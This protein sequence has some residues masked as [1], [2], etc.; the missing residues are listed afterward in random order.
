MSSIRTNTAALS[1]LSTLRSA[2]LDLDRTQERISSGLKIRSAK[3]NAAYFAISSTVAAD[4]GMNKAFEEGLTL[5]RNAISVARLATQSVLDMTKQIGERLMLAQTQY[6]VNPDF[7]GSKIQAEIDAILQRI[8]GTIAQASFNGVSLVDGHGNQHWDSTDGLATGLNPDTTRRTSARDYDIR[9]DQDVP[10][11][12]PARDPDVLHVA[13]GMS[14]GA[15]G[16]A[17]TT[18]PVKKADLVS[19]AEELRSIDVTRDFPA[20]YSGIKG[21]RTYRLGD[22]RI[23][24]YIDL[25]ER[26]R[27]MLIDDAAALGQSEKA[28]ERQQHFLAG[29]TD[30]QDAGVGRLIDADLEEEAARLQAAQVQQQLALQALSIANQ[31]PQNLL[32]LFR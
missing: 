28:V 6:G 19:I 31:A 14:R 32:A 15:S 1:A 25:A 9:A 7:D 30:I 10:G 12:D 18:L 2:N 11:Y 26:A 29:L 23:V 8:R 24:F 17:V 5:T 3:D 16:I 13:T 21:G 27:R 4:S 22:D 20:G